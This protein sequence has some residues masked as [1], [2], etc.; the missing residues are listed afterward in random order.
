M[1]SKI[2]INKTNDLH[3]LRATRQTD[4][5]AADKNKI[6]SI[7]GK[8]EIS[9]DKLQFSEQANEVGKLVDEIKHLPDVREAKVNSLREQI[10]AGNYQPSSEEIADALLREEK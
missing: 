9:G 10:A 4:V 6:D 7:G 1:M 8:Q 2:N 5:K 3:A